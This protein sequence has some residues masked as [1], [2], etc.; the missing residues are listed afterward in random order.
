MY[1]VLDIYKYTINKNI[2]HQF[3]IKYDIRSIMHAT[4]IMLNFVSCLLNNG[5]LLSR[6]M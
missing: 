2:V 6:N 3:G 5:F 4:Y 1:V